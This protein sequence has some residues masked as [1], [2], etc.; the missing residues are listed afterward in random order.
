MITR[1]RLR[2]LTAST[3]GLAGIALLLAGCAGGGTAGTTTDNSSDEETTD[4]ETS[5]ELSGP[6][7]IS[8]LSPN[9]ENEIAYGEAVIEAFEAANPDITV[10]LEIRPGGADG[11][12]IVKTRLATGEM[13][14]VFQYNSGSLFQALNADQ[15]LVEL[16][17][18]P[19]ADKVLDSFWPTVSTANGSY[20]A[21]YGTAMGGGILYNY[22]VY[23]DLGLDI[24]LTWDEFMANN[25]AIDAAGVAPVCQTYGDTWTSQLLVLADYHN[26]EAVEPGF[27]DAYTANQAKY[28][29]SDAA[30]AGFERL[31]EL[32][33]AGYFQEG[34]AS[35]VFND[36]LLAVA[37]GECAHYP[38]LTFAVSTIA[39]LAPDQVDNVGFFAQPGDDAATNGLTVWQ[40]NATY[41]PNTAEGDELIAAKKFVEFM[42]SDEGLQVYI[43]T[44]GQTGPFVIENSPVADDLLPG[45]ADMFPYF[46]A[47]AQS[48][49]ALEFLSPV[50]G[51]S[52]EQLTVATGTGQY[53]A[54]EAAQLYD[55]DVEA[56]AQQLGLEGW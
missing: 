49:S 36:G 27:A 17:N 42:V 20:G 10:E 41:I 47:G 35:A 11:D 33:E 13:N 31:Q 2:G 16:S 48:T 12:N 26:V 39:E 18:E 51:P 40:P 14:E 43:D 19:W 44:N 52:L 30:K 5:T 56:Q 50:K 55:E 9:A 54:D 7:T 53:T 22:N 6:V 1:K 15:T 46:E 45:F 34:Y 8:F 38:M 3:A 23:E 24:P 29:T 25:A 32:H 37:A 4:T 28:A 21:P